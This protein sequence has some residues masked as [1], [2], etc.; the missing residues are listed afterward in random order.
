[1]RVHKTR[2]PPFSSLSSNLPPRPSRDRFAL[3]R[4]PPLWRPASASRAPV[5]FQALSSSLSASASPRSHI[6]PSF[7]RSDWRQAA[8]SLRSSLEVMCYTLPRADLCEAAESP[9]CAMPS[10]PQASL[11]RSNFSAARDSAWIPPSETASRLCDTPTAGYWPRIPDA[12]G[13][14]RTSFCRAAQTNPRQHLHSAL[15]CCNRA[16]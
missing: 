8:K 12:L 3:A 13:N 9:P 10:V 5:L 4:G 7:G 6:Q 2:I 15:V 11:H 1:M 14:I 16:S